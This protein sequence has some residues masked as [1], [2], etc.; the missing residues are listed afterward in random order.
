MVAERSHGIFRGEGGRPLNPFLIRNIF[1]PGLRVHTE[2]RT[3]A[4][5]EATSEKA[6]LEL[7]AEYVA[8]VPDARGFQI[9][10]VEVL[11]AQPVVSR[12]DDAAT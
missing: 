4:T 7:F 9:V 11:D 1:E 6:L 8:T 3:W 5:I 10:T 12:K 2:R